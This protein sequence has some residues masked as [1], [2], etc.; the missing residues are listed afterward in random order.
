MNKT[1]AE[2]SLDKLHD[3]ML[4]DAV[5]FF[6]LAPGWYIA[7]LLFLSL[8]FHF[9]YIRYKRYQADHYRREALSELTTL[10]Q[11]SNENAIVLLSLAKRVG[12]SAYGREEIAGLNEDAWW[13]FMQVHSAVQIE[14]D[15]RS[16]IQKLLYTQ[17]FDLDDELFDTVLMFVT[18][19][20]KTHKV[21]DNV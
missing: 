2:A 11:Q 19:W 4:P 20:I 17:A 18:Q 5:G 12:I 15:M 9:A 1:I 21:A 14:S 8:L 7:L 6:P 10:Q 3:I 13:D 16:E